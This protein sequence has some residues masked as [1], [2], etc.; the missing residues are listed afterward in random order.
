MH[1]FAQESPRWLDKFEPYSLAHAITACAFGGLILGISLWGRRAQGTTAER[2]V[3][4]GLVIVMWAF[5][6][7]YNGFWLW[8]SQFEIGRSLPLQMCD[9]VML[10]APLAIGFEIR[11]A[12]ALLYFW[13]LVLS[14]QGFIQPTLEQGPV[15]WRFWAFWIGHSI[16]V[17]SALYELIAL[18]YRPTIKDLAIAVGAELAYLGAVTAI[19]I[20]FGLDYGFVGP[21]NA[22]TP[23]F[24]ERL[25]PWPMRILWLALLVIGAQIL[26]WAAWPAAGKLQAA[27]GRR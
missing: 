17:G 11:W 23:P 15:H 14:T 1:F 2:R 16:I 13:G 27:R 24:I 4:R 5:L 10:T 9:I 21:P 6:V 7:A 20:P 12:R 3:R 18:R 26:A 25:G 8:P 22:E 19:N